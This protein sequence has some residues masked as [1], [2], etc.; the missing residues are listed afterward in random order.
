MEPTENGNFRLF[1]ADISIYICIYTELTEN[2]N[3][4]LLAANR[5]QRRQTSICF[6]QTET[7]NGSL[8]SLIGKQ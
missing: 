6:L 7:E 8:F 2:G 4:H 1:A 3:F 5:K